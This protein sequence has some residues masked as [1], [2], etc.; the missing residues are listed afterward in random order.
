M[1]LVRCEILGGSAFLAGSGT[2][3]CR[4]IGGRWSGNRGEPRGG[5]LSEI[6]HHGG[7]VLESRLHH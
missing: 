4:L 1:P 5:G 7:E 6:S 3:W 2:P